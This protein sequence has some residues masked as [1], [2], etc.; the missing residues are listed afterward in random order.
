MERKIICQVA[1]LHKEVYLVTPAFRRKVHLYLF[2][3][4]SRDFQPFANKDHDK[5]E[6][7]TKKKAHKLNQLLKTEGQSHGD[8]PVETIW[9]AYDL[10]FFPYQRYKKLEHPS[11]LEY[12]AYNACG[13]Q[14]AQVWKRTT[15]RNITLSATS[16]ELS[17]LRNT[18][19]PQNLKG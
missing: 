7:E 4:T 1:I 16:A 10:L 18:K 14:I 2:V 17:T 12:K 15:L 9:T 11:S 3:H 13:L 19:S 6:W 5:Y 8:E